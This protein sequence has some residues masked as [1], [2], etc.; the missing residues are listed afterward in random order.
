[1]FAAFSLALACGTILADASGLCGASY[2]P[3]A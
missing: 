3:E 1:L 2:Q